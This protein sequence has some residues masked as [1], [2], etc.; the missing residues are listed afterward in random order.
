MNLLKVLIFL[1][2]LTVY[3]LLTY[4]IYQAFVEN[5][6]IETALFLIYFF[7]LSIVIVITKGEIG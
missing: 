5:M 6:Y 3:G 2:C 4:C 7:G 1:F